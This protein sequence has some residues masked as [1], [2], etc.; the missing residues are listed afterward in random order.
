VCTESLTED[1]DSEEDIQNELAVIM[2]QLGY[3]LQMINNE[4]EA[5]AVYNDTLKS[6]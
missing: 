3:C 5:L 6:K 1:G 2:V 4:E